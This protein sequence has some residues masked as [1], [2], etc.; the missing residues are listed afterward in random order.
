MP[1]PPSLL[2]FFVPVIILDERR[3]AEKR[4][5]CFVCC[6][7]QSRVD[8]VDEVEE[9]PQESSFD[10]F[11]GWFAEQLFRPW[12]KLLVIVAFMGLLAGCAYSASQLIQEFDFTDVVPNGS[13]V[14]A[15]WDNFDL[16]T[17]QSGIRP[18]VYFRYV[19]QSDPAIQDQ[20]ES[21][22]N[23]L[24]ALK[25][26]TDPPVFFWL[27]DFKQF[28]NETTTIQN[29]TFNQQV[30][31]FLD[32]PVYYEIY[33]DDIVIDKATGNILA[34]RTDLMMDNVDEKDVVKQVDALQAQSDV[35]ANQ[36]VNRGRKDWAFFTF[37]GLY[38]IWEFYSASPRELGQT[39]ILGV[40]A[41]TLIAFLLIP[42]WSAALFVCPFICILYIDL[43]GVLQ[44]AG[45][46]VN[47][48][49]YISL[50]MSIGLLVDFLMHVLLR[51]YES[52]MDGREAKVK[53]TLKTMGSSILVGGISTFLGVIPL[54]FSTSEVFNTIFVTFIG[55]VTL[56]AGHGLIL[57]PVVLSM[58]GPNVCIKTSTSSS[59]AEQEGQ[60]EQEQE[61]GVDPEKG[62]EV[63]M[64]T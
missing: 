13:Y 2:I 49:S 12:M 61:N 15:F 16:Y 5:D 4:R 36:P 32:D 46:H 56:G 1:S 63:A 42:H 30:A 60:Q 43:L 9:E 38:F 55:L 35:S 58:F 10:R 41:V 44:F 7:V 52:P 24:V 6:T 19:D 48:V 8:N 20:M 39:T 50:A 23:D 33:A 64:E 26:I 31:A 18:F 34:S 45:L 37:D 28:V 29:M 17:D 62:D 11:M 27:H 25:E 57:L 47:A 53:D 51:Y 14:T 40:V 22:V 54:A 59:S 3:V 21:Y